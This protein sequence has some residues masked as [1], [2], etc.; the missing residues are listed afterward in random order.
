MLIG[1][2]LEHFIA[3]RN[4]SPRYLESLRRTV[5]RAAMYGLTNV[6]QMT[7]ES[8]NQFLGNLRDLS[9]E[10]VSNIRR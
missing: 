3:S 6:C 2:L 7:N 5:R 4:P 10:T 8:V 9:A 1:D